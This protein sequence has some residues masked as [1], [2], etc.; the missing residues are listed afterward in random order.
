MKGCYVAGIRHSCNF[1]DFCDFDF[2]E[3]ILNVLCRAKMLSLSRC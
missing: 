3:I 1:C 2:T